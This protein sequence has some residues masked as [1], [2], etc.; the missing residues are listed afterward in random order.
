MLSFAL[1]SAR[2]APR[3]YD[4][5]KVSKGPSF[6]TRFTLACPYTLLAHYRELD[7][8]ECCGVPPHLIRVSVGEEDPKALRDIFEDALRSG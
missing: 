2:K 8:A 3:V 6:G 1:K 4:A 7:W 5:L